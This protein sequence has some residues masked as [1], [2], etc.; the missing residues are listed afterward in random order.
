PEVHIHRVLVV[1]FHPLQRRFIDG[2]MIHDLVEDDDTVRANR[3]GQ[4][5]GGKEQDAPEHESSTTRNSRAGA[6]SNHNETGMS[7]GHSGTKWGWTRTNQSSARSFRG[8]REA[9]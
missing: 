4:E 3:E 1:K 2:G 6:E 8:H 5:D 9:N 7:E